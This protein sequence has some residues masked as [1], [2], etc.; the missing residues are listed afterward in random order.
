MK[1]KSIDKMAEQFTSPEE[2]KAYSEAQFKTILKLNE[3][4]NSLKVECE[5]L[6]QENK[7]LKQKTITN[8]VSGEKNQFEVSNEEATC[9]VQI[10][11]IKNNALERELTMDE[12]KR[13]EIFVKILQSL[14]N[15][16]KPEKGEDVSGLSD[17]EIKRKMDEALKS[18]Q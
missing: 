14:R 13:L 16:E 15:K 9:V 6:I 2:L 8:E 17:D 11:L 12:T 18:P 7:A 5:Q 3:E 1:N 10:A 4:I